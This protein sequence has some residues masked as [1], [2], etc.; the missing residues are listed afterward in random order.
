MLKNKIHNQLLQTLEELVPNIKGKFFVSDG[1]LLGI[2]RDNELLPWDGDIDLY[3]LEDTEI[4]LDLTN[5]KKQEY[6]ICDKIYNPNY[7]PQY[8]NPWLEYIAYQ[9]LKPENKNLNR[10]QLTKKISQDYK[11]EKKVIEYTFPHIDIFI[12]KKEGDK[13]VYKDGI[14][15]Q[16]Y[17]TQNEIDNL[18]PIFFKGIPIYIPKN[19]EVILERL[20]GPTWKIPNP[21]HHYY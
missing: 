20:Y 9:R 2:T 7:E 19:K 3:I 11:N 4:N 17:Y 12:L 18:E 1:A 6:Y 13:Y 10:A 21:N 14:W 16:M 5:L 8:A 15:K